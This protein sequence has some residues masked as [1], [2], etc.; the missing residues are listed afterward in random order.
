MSEVTL[1]AARNKHQPNTKPEIVV[2]QETELTLP[3]TIVLPEELYLAV[4]RNEEKNNRDR[5]KGTSHQAVEL[6]STE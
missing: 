3:V 6:G 5:T 2:Q 1:P 4:E